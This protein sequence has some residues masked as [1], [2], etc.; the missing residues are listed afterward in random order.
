MSRQTYY[1]NVPTYRNR[2]TYFDDE[3]DVV[4]VGDVR[5]RVPALHETLNE[6]R[7]TADRESQSVEEVDQQIHAIVNAGQTEQDE[8]RHGDD[9]SQVDGTGCGLRPP[10]I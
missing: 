8:T 9:R 10:V 7:R 1:L 6:R 4:S 3:V 2:S 5:R